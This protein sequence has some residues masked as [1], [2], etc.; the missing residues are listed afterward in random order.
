VRA[1][2]WY[3]ATGTDVDALE[4]AY[5]EIGESLVG[6]PGLRG[7]ELLR[8]VSAPGEFVVA[9]EWESLHAFRAWADD[10][11]H[12]DYTGKL[13]AFRDV[14]RPSGRYELFEIAGIATG[15]P[16]DPDRPEREAPR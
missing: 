16:D 6:T 3:R 8:S 12:R 4:Q 10:P 5:K 2:L 7:N 9:S 11:A 1:L 13:D 14:D 15:Q